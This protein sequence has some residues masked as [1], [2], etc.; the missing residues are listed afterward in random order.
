MLPMPTRWCGVRGPP[1]TR[2][3]ARD[4]YALYVGGQEQENTR[5][6]V[7]MGDLRRAIEQDHLRLYCQPKLNIDWRGVCGAEALVR[8]Q[9][10]QFV[11]ASGRP[12]RGY[13]RLTAGPFRV[14][15]SMVPAAPA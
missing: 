13:S 11:C 8:W 2:Q 14:R 10:P 9:H 1:C 15:H 6:L 3:G 5:R 7:L 12:F 4:G